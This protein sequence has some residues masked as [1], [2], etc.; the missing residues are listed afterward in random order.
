MNHCR[1]D[2][3]VIAIDNPRAYAVYGAICGGE[4]ATH[5]AQDGTAR[6]TRLHLGDAMIELAEPVARAAS[7]AG[8]EIARR[9]QRAGPGIHL[10]CL[11]A[12]DLE[13]RTAALDAAG[14]A[15]IRR[16]GHVYVHP[17]GANGVLVQLTPR[18]EFGPKPAAG[19]AIL[20]HVAI[21]VRDLEEAEKRWAIITGE[22]AQP[23]GVHPISGGAFAATRFE[24]GQRM[25]ELLSPTPGM[26]SALAERLE[27]HGEGVAALAVPASDIDATLSR[28]RAV[29]ARV[30]RQEPHW[31][32]HPR[33]AAGVLV[34]LTPRVRH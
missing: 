22:P 16:D 27:S 23:M 28:L 26:Q 7:G 8:G 12:T 15:L 32:V 24:L 4:S 21:R 3:V 31:M 34:Q 30:L 6:Y 19:D 10:V 14:I 1:L 2:H 5:A 33:D 18:R 25:V 13:A 29:G 20:D 9:M 11:P 17:R